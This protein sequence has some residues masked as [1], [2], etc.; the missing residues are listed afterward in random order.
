ML[1]D[2]D[3]PYMQIKKNGSLKKT[4]TH[5]NLIPKEKSNQEKTRQFRKKKKKIKKRK[6]KKKNS[7]IL[8]GGKGSLCF[9][10]R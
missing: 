1:F 6:K 10:P 4:Y 8:F 7:I 2:L 5:F 3:N 9:L